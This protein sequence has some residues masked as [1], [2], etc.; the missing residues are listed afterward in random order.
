[1]KIVVVQEGEYGK[2]LV[3]Y[4]EKTMPEDSRLVLFTGEAGLKDWKETADYYL[5]A[6][7][8]SEEFL[9]EEKKIHPGKIMILGDD[10]KEGVFCRSDTPDKLVRLLT[11]QKEE[12]VQEEA[13]LTLLFSPVYIE[14]L[15]EIAFRFMKQKGLYLGMEDLGSGD[16]A[17]MG[18]LSYYIHLREEEILE[19]LS[20]MVRKTEEGYL[21]D[22]PDMYFYLRE[23]TMEDYQWF[24]HKLRDER[25]YPEVVV[26]AGS[27]FL[28]KPEMLALFDRIILVDSVA[29]AAQH[30]FCK[31]LM[32]LVSD[33]YYAQGIEIRT[34]DKT[35]Y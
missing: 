20:A 7:E 5:L 11:E 26:G 19:R 15:S 10:R 24:F 2:R 35:N 33:G 16:G 22:S 9:S 21:L 29:S 6:E 25:L 14:N 23:L 13:Y 18:D 1:M 17:D 34:I 32:K 12:N 28:K 3:D 30:R 31:R 4:L 27:G 8:L